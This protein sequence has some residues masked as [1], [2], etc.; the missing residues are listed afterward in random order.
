M[1]GNP[2]QKANKSGSDGFA[3]LEFTQV[4]CV[5]R[6]SADGLFY[7][8]LLSVGIEVACHLLLLLLVNVGPLQGEDPQRSQLSF[9]LLSDLFF[10]VQ[11][12]N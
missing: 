12:R 6:C 9:F 1:P 4:A 7:C 11:W 5:S 3:V 10:A 8:V 2:S